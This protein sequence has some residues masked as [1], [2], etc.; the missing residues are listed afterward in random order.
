MKIKYYGSSGESKASHCLF[1][2]AVLLKFPLDIVDVFVTL[3]YIFP[4]QA[5]MC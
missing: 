4:M 5:C 3:E 1:V 2:F